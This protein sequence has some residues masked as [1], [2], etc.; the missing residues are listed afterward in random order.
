MFRLQEGAGEAAGGCRGR[1]IYPEG[2]K[3]NVSSHIDNVSLKLKETVSRELRR[4][5]LCIN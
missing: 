5:L 2:E 1:T 3:G 4:V